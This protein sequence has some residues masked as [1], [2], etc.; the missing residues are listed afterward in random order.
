MATVI[1]TLLVTIGLKSVEFEAGVGKSKAEL[2]QLQKEAEETTK[3]LRELGQRG[4][5]SMKELAVHALEFMGVMASIGAMVAFTEHTVKAQVAMGRLAEEAHVTVEDL[6]ALQIASVKLG[7][8]EEGVN[9]S[10]TSLGE[11]MSV[12]GTRVR[13][14][15][16]AA[17]GFEQLGLNPIHMKGKP[18]AETLQIISD[19]MRGMEFFKAKKLGAILGVT[20]EGMIRAMIQGGEEF[21]K[22]T[23][24]ARK[25]AATAEDVKSAR[26]FEDQQKDLTATLNKVGMTLLTTVMPALHAFMDGF[27]RMATWMQ[28]HQAVLKAILLGVAAGFAAVGTAAVIMG[29]QAAIAWVIATWPIVLI[30]AAVALVAAGLYLLI[31]HIKEVSN[32]FNWLAYHVVFFLL[33]SWYMVK[34]AAIEMW[35]DIKKAAEAPLNW[36]YDKIMSIVDA[37]KQYGKIFVSLAHGDI[38]GA[39]SAAKTGAR[40]IVHVAT[41]GLVAGALAA[42]TNVSTPTRSKIPIPSAANASMPTRP[43][44]PTPIAN[45]SMSMRPSI[46]NTNAI[47]NTRTTSVGT[48]NIVTQATDA[49]GVA[50]GIHGALQ[51][52]GGLVDQADGGL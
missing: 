13:G 40:D 49:P 1:D 22:I 52:Q 25:Y 29:V 38:G 35:N 30:V 3:K 9:A 31:T 12:L 26:E 45:A 6:S 33:K 4:G 5:D 48:V 47:T 23:D 51:K 14:A 42:S 19:K 2:K 10:I 50:R 24:E 15:K 21:R 8:S 16:Q 36:V 34:Q 7:G 32:W 37:V 28:G 39:I 43:K 44:I 17:I 46:S 41:Y 27:Q 18:V 11:K 20:D